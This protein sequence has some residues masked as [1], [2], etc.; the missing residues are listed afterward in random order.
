MYMDNN[1]RFTVQDNQ[2]FGECLPCT[3]QVFNQ[4]VDASSTAWKIDT[5]RGV[6]Q[7]VS[8]GRLLET[9]KRCSDF[10]RWCQRQQKTKSFDKLTIEQKLLQWAQSLKSSLPC[11]IFGVREFQQVI[12]TRKDGSQRPFRRRKQPNV[13]QLSGLFM[14]DADHLLMDPREVYERTLAPDFPWQIC[15]AHK[16]SS[17]YGLRLVAECRPELGRIADNQI[18]LARDLQLMGVKGS[19]GKYVVDDSCIDCSRISYAPKRSDIYF[20]DEN[21][22]FNI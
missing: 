21:K 9:Y 10:H 4:Y 5:R 16:T 11:F 22:L 2:F 14:F 8:E 19:T 7:A 12:V 3:L 6:E 1:F 17:G 20:I 13:S 18:C 15:L